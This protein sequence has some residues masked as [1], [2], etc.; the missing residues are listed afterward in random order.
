[1]SNFKQIVIDALDMPAIEEHSANKRKESLAA[2][3]SSKKIFFGR[4]SEPC[5]SE[6]LK[7]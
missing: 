7:D 4:K 1:M 5:R 2:K 3:A 6:R